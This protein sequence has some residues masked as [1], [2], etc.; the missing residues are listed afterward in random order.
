MT[1]T[2]LLQ[3]SENRPAEL[4]VGASVIGVPVLLT[5]VRCTLQYI[6]VPFV[7]P[8]LSATDTFSPQVNIGAGLFGLSV[9]GFNLTRL[10]NTNWRKRYLWISLVIVPIILITLYFDYLAYFN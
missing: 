5:A 4:Y 2:K 8:L 10:W 3:H 6:V 7:L 9:V 1:E